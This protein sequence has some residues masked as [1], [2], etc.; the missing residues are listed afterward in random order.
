MINK[1]K[2]GRMEGWRNRWM[3]GQ[4]NIGKNRWRN[5]W[6]VG[7]TYGD[8]KRT[9]NKQTDGM[10]GHMDEGKNVSLSLSGVLS[11]NCF[12]HLN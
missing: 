11:Q 7:L 1:Q 3:K 2:D 8:T 10:E 6:I 9:I 5:L 4:L 12:I